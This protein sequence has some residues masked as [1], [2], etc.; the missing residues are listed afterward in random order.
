MIVHFKWFE[1]FLF[2]TGLH[3]VLLNIA[4]SVLKHKEIKPHAVNGQLPL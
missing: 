3:P 2:K 1:L 4:L